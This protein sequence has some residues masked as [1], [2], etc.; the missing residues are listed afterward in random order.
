MKNKGEIKVKDIKC[1]D[2]TNERD[3]W[4]L[5]GCVFEG[6]RSFRGCLFEKK[7][8]VCHMKKIKDTF[9]GEILPRG[10]FRGKNTHSSNFGW[11]VTLECVNESRRF[12][13]R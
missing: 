7:G 3:I 1:Q 2:C 11:D 10:G 13:L 5:L 6:R 4:S 12:F 8:E 9:G